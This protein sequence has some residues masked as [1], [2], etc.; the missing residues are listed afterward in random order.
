M[1]PSAGA[2]QKGRSRLTGVI[3][4][5]VVL[6]IL[7]ALAVPV[8][9]GVI[10]EAN[11]IACRN[12]LLQIGTALQN[13]ASWHHDAYP[14][15]FQADS[16]HWNDVGNTRTDEWEPARDP[17]DP[18]EAEPGDNGTPI[19]SNTANLWKLVA[20]AGAP[21]GVFICPGR[22]RWPRDVAERSDDWLHHGGFDYDEVRDFRGELYCHYSFQNVL[23][24]YILKQPGSYQP[25]RMV[26]VADASPLRRDVWSGAPDGVADG[27]TDE[28]LADDPEFEETET[29]QRWNEAGARPKA[30]ELCSPNHDFRKMNVHFLDGH[31]ETVFHPYCGPNHDNIWLRRKDVPVADIDPTDLATLRATNDTASYD[32]TSTLP[33]DSR[34]DSFLVP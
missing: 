21:E 26:V 6:G 34:N 17:A 20:A 11:M 3:I 25:S 15:V 2:S 10:A 9:R 16:T 24:A 8:I 33:V 1:P 7:T 22:G 14:D 18:P 23:G 30:W 32:G 12:N 19:Q 27:A 13:W 4:L 5:V 31:S 29:T 28:Y